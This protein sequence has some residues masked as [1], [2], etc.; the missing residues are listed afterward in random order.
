MSQT[1]SIAGAGADPALNRLHVLLADDQII[2]AMIIGKLL[3]LLGCTM[4]HVEDGQQAVERWRQGRFDL[5]LM[6]VQM[7]VLNGF[8]ATARIRE[9]ERS[10]AGSGHM[11]VVALTANASPEDRERSLA[12]GMDAHLSKPI[13]VDTLAQ[14]MRAAITA[15]QMPEPAPPAP[16]AINL[17]RLLESLGGAE[18]LLTEFIEAM[19]VELHQRMTRLHNAGLASNAAQACAQAHALRG[20]LGSVGATTAAALTRKLENSARADEWADFQLTLAQLKDELR[21]IESALSAIR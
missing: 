20:A 6:D 7:P 4:E 9:L 8:E 14:A 1:I 18:E 5:I 3:S 17:T 15:R 13:T 10:G 11:P 16:S 2:N 12:A 19:Q 21:G